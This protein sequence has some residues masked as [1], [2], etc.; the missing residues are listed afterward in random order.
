[1]DKIDASGGIDILVKRT[2]DMAELTLTSGM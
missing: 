1:M 2:G